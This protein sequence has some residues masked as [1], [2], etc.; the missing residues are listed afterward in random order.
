MW[1]LGLFAAVALLAAGDA[2]PAVTGTDWVGT[3]AHISSTVVLA[4]VAAKLFD[5]IVKLLDGLKDVSNALTALQQNCAARAAEQHERQ[6]VR[7]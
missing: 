2:A 4:G 1:K 3:G 5:L 6:E 7:S